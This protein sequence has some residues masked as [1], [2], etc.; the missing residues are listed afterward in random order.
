M[1]EHTLDI[2]PDRRDK[3]FGPLFGEPQDG[4]EKLDVLVPVGHDHCYLFAGQ[5]SSH[6]FPL[7]KGVVTVQT[8][9]LNPDR[10]TA[11]AGRAMCFLTTS[12][13]P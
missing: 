13:S 10:A 7:L 6:L 4:E 2:L 8:T 5:L 12:I 1:P 3:D 11:H 9:L